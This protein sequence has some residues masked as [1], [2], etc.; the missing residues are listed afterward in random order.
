MDRGLGKK[1]KEKLKE[2]NMP[3]TNHLLVIGINNYGE[4][5][6]KLNNAVKDA[7]AFE[8]L[9]NKKYGFKEDNIIPLY[10]EDATTDN[11]LDAFDT[12]IK[13]LTEDDNLIFYFSGHGELIKTTQQGYWIPVEA[14]AN[15]RGDYLINTEIKNFVAACRARHI[16][17]VIDACYSGSLLR[18][19]TNPLLQKYFTKPSRRV[20]TSGL[21]EPVPDGI[22]NHHSP[23]AAALLSSLKHNKKPYLSTSALWQDMQEGLAANSFASAQFESMHGVGHQGGDFF[24]LATGF[25]EIP[26]V[27]VHE[28]AGEGASRNINPPPERVTPPVVDP[29]VDLSTLSLSDWKIALKRLAVTNLKRALTQAEG[30]IDTS[31]DAFNSLLLLQSRF[32]STNKD[33]NSGMVT[34]QQSKISFNRIKAA[35]T[36]F[37]DDLE[38]YDTK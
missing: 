29:E 7:K 26:E 22:P 18:K 34:D 11:I 12:L 23:F 16:L 21:I 3:T 19:I 32:H 2:A 17:G 14:R 27:E 36:G 24:F 13:K 6:P 10:N 15:R 28:T 20:I 8:A 5:I 30:R 33:K 35:F 1:K 31:S 25:E 9:L 37:L 38:E 4:G